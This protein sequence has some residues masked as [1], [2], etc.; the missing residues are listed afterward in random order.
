MKHGHY[1]LPP[2]VR[3][4][5][6][7]RKGILLTDFMATGTTITSEVNCETLNKFRRLIQNK[8]RGFLIKGVVLLDDNARPHTAARTN[9]LIKL[10]Q[11]G[12]FRPSSLE[13]GPGTKRLPSL[14]QDEGLFGYP[15]PPH[16][17]RTRGW[18]QHLTA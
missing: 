1:Q 2:A 7:D 12:G 4:V 6:S 17:R 13:S 9:A 15:A 11:R 3:Y 14:H 8:R 5:F 18:S 10:F 16:Q